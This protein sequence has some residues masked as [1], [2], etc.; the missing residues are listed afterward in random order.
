MQTIRAA[1]LDAALRARLD[2]R[3]AGDEGRGDR[4]LPRRFIDRAIEHDRRPGQ[5]GRRLP[6]RLAGGDLRRAAPRARQ[7]AHDRRRADRLPR[8]RRGDPRLRP[9]ARPRRPA[10][11]RGVVAPRRRRPEGRV[12][13]RRL[14]RHQARERGRQAAAAARATSTTPTTSS[15]TA[16]SRTGSSTR[17]TSRARSTCGSSSTCSATTSSSAATLTVGGERVDLG[18]IRLPAEPAG[19]R[20]RPHHA[21]GAGLRARRRRLDAAA[22]HH[23]AHDERRPPRA[24]HGT[25]ALRDHWPPIIADVFE[26]SQAVAAP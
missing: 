23:P 24:V 8:R 1:G 9:G 17:R 7:H 18:A 12:H 4:R 25:E 20:D 16:P 19:R 6:G 2:R 14:H 13:A 15:A 22:A 26:R 11:L 5:P 21:A 3:D 10:L